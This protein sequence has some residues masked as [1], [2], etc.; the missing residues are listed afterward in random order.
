MNPRTQVLIQIL[1]ATCVLA[2]PSL[3]STTAQAAGWSGWARCELDIR[4][5]GYE[6]KETH[7]WIVSNVTGNTMATQG[8]GTWS[9]A[10]KGML[11]VGNPQTS[12][13]HSE[14]SVN[15][16]SSNGR[17]GVSVNN[18]V[19]T[20]RPYH[21]QL[22]TSSGISGYSVYTANNNTRAP[23]YYTA[24]EYEW[25]FPVVQGPATNQTLI[26]SSSGVS[27]AG[28]GS[29]RLSGSTMNV[30]CQWTFA[31]GSTPALPPPVAAVPIPVPG[32][33]PPP[34]PPPPPPATPS[35][36]CLAFRASPMRLRS[37]VDVSIVGVVPRSFRPGERVTVCAA[38]YGRG[39]SGVALEDRYTD[40]LSLSS[41]E[42]PDTA[43]FVMIGKGSVMALNPV[44]SARGDR[45]VFTVG[46][47][48]RKSERTEFDVLVP[49]VSAPRGWV[50][51]IA[52]RLQGEAAPVTGPQVMWRQQ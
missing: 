44:I 5:P 35:D 11:D 38:S 23:T 28:W 50:G 25:A 16:N 21:S 15:G 45:L 14:W 33:P 3:W 4:G 51:P 42:S 17:F 43:T 22:G 46:G 30:S 19:L 47:L 36:P 20:L 9:A 1:S 2:L 10:G 48:Y 26:G 12:H 41:L 8:P 27:A 37:R 34:P 31:N 7:T 40:H 39:L 24:T 6:N 13:N 29:Q 49:V 18:G 52:I 32:S